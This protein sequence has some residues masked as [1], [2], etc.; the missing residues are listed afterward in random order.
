MYVLD[1]SQND[2]SLGLRGQLS[3]F[4]F[5]HACFHSQVSPRCLCALL[6]SFTFHVADVQLF[7][8][9]PDLSPLLSLSEKVSPCPWQIQ[10]NLWGLRLG[11]DCVFLQSQSGIFVFFSLAMSS[12]SLTI[13][14][15]QIPAY[16]GPFDKNVSGAKVSWS[17]FGFDQ[18]LNP[19]LFPTRCLQ[20]ACACGPRQLLQSTYHIKAPTCVKSN[21]RLPSSPSTD[22]CFPSETDPGHRICV[23][24]QVIATMGGFVPKP[25]AVLVKSQISCPDEWD[26]CDLYF[27]PGEE[28]REPCQKSKTPLGLLLSYFHVRFFL[29]E[30]CLSEKSFVPQKIA[31]QMTETKN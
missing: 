7:V 2:Q 28:N 26:F 22:Y 17:S 23:T 9:L 24:S 12:F 11:T 14:C 18:I 20:C 16:R 27:F 8:L 6:I 30:T 10:G 13:R 4:L 25:C 21:L 15:V 19:R 1:L 29:Q 31:P 5:S 3:L